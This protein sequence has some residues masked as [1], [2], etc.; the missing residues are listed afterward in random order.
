MN[1]NFRLL[2]DEN[3]LGLAKSLRMMGV[4]S[5]VL[6]GVSDDELLGVAQQQGRIILTK[7][8]RFFQRIPQEQAYFVQSEK[9]RDQLIEVLQKYP[10]AHDG[11]PLS[12]CFQCNSLIELVA[13]DSI[14]GRVDEK[15][16]G[17]Y[18]KFY[19][20]PRCHRVYWE[21]SHFVKLQGK[22]RDIKKSLG[23]S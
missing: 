9:P 15:T 12:R 7:D 23:L 19:E 4:D 14:Q 11:E 17:L 22:V 21:G 6:L 16:Y 2:V 8:R 3:L 20:C 18:D 13:K 1:E 10:M 5:L